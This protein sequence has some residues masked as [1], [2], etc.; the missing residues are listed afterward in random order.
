VRLD[1]PRHPDRYVEARLSRDAGGRLV[2]QVT[3]RSGTALADVDVLVE[4][5][6]ASGRVGRLRTR[7]D[8]LPAGS[9]RVML[10]SE[11]GGGLVDARA[12]V[13]GARI[14]G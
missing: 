1:L 3:N 9:A 14:D 11:Q 10:V 13:V 12:V 6:D 2:M 5:T 7:V 4:A 8:R